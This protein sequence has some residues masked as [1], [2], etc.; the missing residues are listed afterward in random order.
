MDNDVCASTSTPTQRAFVLKALKNNVS[1]NTF[2]LR[3]LGLCS[4]AARLKEL[5]DSG[6]KINSIRE[7]A[8]DSIGV[9][10]R[11]VSR[12]WL[13]EIPTKELESIALKWKAH[14]AIAK[15]L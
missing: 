15:Q 8:T 11:N 2:E 14:P 7:T 6:V 3:A 5:I 13:E 9:R 4:P 12:Y 1:L 10:H